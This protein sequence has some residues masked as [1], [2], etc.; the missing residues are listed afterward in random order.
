MRLIFQTIA[1]SVALSI[2]SAAAFAQ[3]SPITERDDC[4]SALRGHAELNS[5]LMGYSILKIADGEV[6]ETKSGVKCSARFEASKD[7]KG[8][9]T[10][11]YEG[12]AAKREK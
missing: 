4:I 12:E 6:S 7:G 5:K 9:L 8:F 1:L 3:S 11:Y 2:A 10:E